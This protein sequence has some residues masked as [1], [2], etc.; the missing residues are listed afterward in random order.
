MEVGDVDVG[1]GKKR[2]RGRPCGSLGKKPLPLPIAVSAGSDFSVSVFVNI[3]MP[4]VVVQSTTPHGSDKI[5]K[6]PTVQLGPLQIHGS[7]CWRQ[8]LEGMGRLSGAQSENLVIPS[9]RW[10]WSVTSPSK[11]RNAPV[12]HFLPL[13]D[14][15]AFKVL[16]TAVRDA[17]AA[18]SLSGSEIILITMAQPMVA[19]VSQSYLVSLSV[20]L[21][22]E[23]GL[24]DMWEA[25]GNTGAFGALCARIHSTSTYPC[26]TGVSSLAEAR[27][28][29]WEEGMFTRPCLRWLGINV[30]LSL[31]RSMSSW[32]TSLQS[33]DGGTSMKLH[34]ATTTLAIV[35]SSSTICISTSIGQ[36]LWC[37]EMH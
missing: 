23:S 11:G 22:T 17:S 1:E 8:L 3:E 30:L 32:S 29:Q 28:V 14:E 13:G 31:P 25:I 15:N 10:T 27:C 16:H 19:S 36:S 7:T 34:S 12:H 37:G 2:K 33:C 20:R 21:T 5:I 24:I 35:V 6:P 9:M 4:Q 26:H 18:G